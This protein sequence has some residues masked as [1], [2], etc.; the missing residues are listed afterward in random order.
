VLIYVLL[1][2]QSRPD[3]LM[4]LRLLL[5]LAELWDTQKREWE[6]AG[7]SMPLRLLPVVP[8]VFYTGADAWNMPIGLSSLMD[9]PPALQRFVPTWETLFLNL[10]RTPPSTLTQFSTAVG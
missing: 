10:H 9:L 2:H 1:E 3:S 8:L 7:R 4:G 6:D 5:Y